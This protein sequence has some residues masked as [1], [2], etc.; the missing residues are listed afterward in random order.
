ML[1]LMV[2]PKTALKN[3]IELEKLSM[4]GQF[5]FYESI[6]FTPGRIKLLNNDKK[7]AIIKS[8]MVHHQGMSLV[9]MDNVINDNIMQKRF[10]NNV[11]VK[12]ADILL[13]EKVPADV[14][15]T[16]DNKEKVV[17]AKEIKVSNID[18][19]RIIKNIGYE[20]PNVHILTNG[21]YYTMINDRGTGFS[22]FRNID[23][24]RKRSDFILE[25][26]GQIFYIKCINNGQI[27]TSSYQPTLKKPDKYTVMF[28]GDKAKIT[29]VDGKI[30]T[31]QEVV[32]ST[33]DNLE[34]RK[35]I[36]NLKR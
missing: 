31:I 7:Y 17:P 6:D 4:L 23:I 11:F 21:S 25:N 22:K 10:H 19:D 27:W 3:L 34:I 8:Y 35:I 15:Y 9:A 12:S 32:V 5:G 30:E 2:K 28:S 20:R 13:Q 24:S 26:S 29:R 1:A 18:T 33:E 16:K 36:I 14:I